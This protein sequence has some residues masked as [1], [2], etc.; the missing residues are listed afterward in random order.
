MNKA[1]PWLAAGLFLLAALLFFRLYLKSTE[2]TSAALDS[3][4]RAL[5][6]LGEHLAQKQFGS[7]ALV[8]SNPFTQKPGQPKEIQ[9]F[10]N[11]GIRGLEQGL[12]DATQI[13]IVF[14]KIKPE[15]QENP[16]LAVIPQN[17]KTPLSFLID[18]TSI[19]Q[20]AASHTDCQLLVSLIGLPL[21]VEKLKIW[22]PQNPFQFALLLPDLRIIGT[23]AKAVEAFKHGKIT[24]AVVTESESD[25]PLIIDAE[26]V[27]DILSSRPN[28]LGFRRSR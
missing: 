9:K 28:L 27:Q 20:I 11:A 23:K 26:N 1:K 15:Y 21:G 5:L 3:R 19:D 10:E 22:Q 18:A 17:I 16:P 24:A 2:E 13:K 8:L 4:Q 25:E 6:A 12:P 14:P 7:C